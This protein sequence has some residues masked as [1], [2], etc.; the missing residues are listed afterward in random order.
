VRSYRGVGTASQQAEDCNT[1][2]ASEGVGRPG[3]S[4]VVRPLPQD[5]VEGAGGGTAKSGLMPVPPASV[6]SS[7]IAPSLNVMNWVTLAARAELNSR[8]ALVS[9]L[10]PCSQALAIPLPVLSLPEIKYGRIGGAV[11]QEA[12]LR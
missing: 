9:R 4:G 11:L 7:G 12:A 2:A 3:V 8:V 6:A 5:A 1:A 10:H